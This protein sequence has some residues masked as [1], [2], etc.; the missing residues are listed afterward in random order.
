MGITTSKETVIVYLDLDDT[1]VAWKA[2]KGGKAAGGSIPLSQVGRLQPEGT[3]GV[4]LIGRDGKKLVEFEGQSEWE[5]DEWLSGMQVAM[6]ERGNAEARRSRSRD[7]AQQKE[8]AAAAARQESRDRYWKERK[9]GLD[10]REQ[11]ASAR[12]SKYASD[13]AS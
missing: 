9:A 10:K 1:A 12:R 8:D 3:A 6:A 13:D 7:A 4:S 2:L 11:M 5:R